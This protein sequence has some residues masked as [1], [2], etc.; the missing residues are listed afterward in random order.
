MIVFA[1]L[2]LCLFIL[3]HSSTLLI[4]LLSFFLE[5]HCSSVLLLC[6]FV[7][8]FGLPFHRWSLFRTQLVTVFSCFSLHLPFLLFLCSHSSSCCVFV[9]CVV[10]LLAPLLLLLFLHDPQEK[11]GET[12]ILHFDLLLPCPF[13][14]LECDQEGFND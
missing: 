9:Y 14:H 4:T 8:L 10:S 1:Y 3:A 11:M 13:S 6:S 7:S 12:V 5:R 2:F